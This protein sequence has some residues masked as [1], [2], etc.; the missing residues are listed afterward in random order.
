MKLNRVEL[1]GNVGNIDI[2][3]SEGKT[4]F[5]KVSLAENNRYLNK[6][7]ETVQQ[8]IWHNVVFYDKQ[9]EVE[10]PPS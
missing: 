7:G 5:A 8:A 9:V 10:S 2:Y 3:E 1:A 6:A 4:P